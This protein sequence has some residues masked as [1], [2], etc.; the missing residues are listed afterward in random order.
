[1][2]IMSFN[3]Q[4]CLNFLEQKIDYECMANAI[5]KCRAD[6]VGLNEMYGIS[7][8]ASENSQELGEQVKILSRLTGLKH[9][10]FARA[11]TDLPWGDYGNGFISKYK[12]VSSETIMIPDPIEKS[13]DGHY[14]TR[15]ILKVVLE[16]G[17]TVLVTHFGLCPDEQENAVKT[18]LENVKSEKCILM[19]DF[20]VAPDNPLLKP[21]YERMK[22]T[23]ILFNEEK[24]S[25]P[26][27]KPKMKIDYIFVSPDIEIVNA[28][29]PE[30][31]ASD[32]RPHLTEIKY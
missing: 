32:H 11:I 23:A 16:N 7:K 6:I 17:L 14:E 18:V 13:S 8:N 15:C 9:H 1:M 28:D 24:L 21:I 26:S 30:L 3:T 20:N 10:Y 22:D 29:I 27:D 4:H 25:W 2:K 5:L 31:V 19:G 12:I